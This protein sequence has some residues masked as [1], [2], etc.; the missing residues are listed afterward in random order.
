VIAQTA[1]NDEIKEWATARL[2]G[3]TDT[4]INLE[5]NKHLRVRSKIQRHPSLGL[6]SC[7]P[8]VAPNGSYCYEDRSLHIPENTNRHALRFRAQIH[9]GVPDLQLA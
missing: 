4:Q 3:W 5:I 7:W 6:A 2:P 9:G 1:Q 8:R